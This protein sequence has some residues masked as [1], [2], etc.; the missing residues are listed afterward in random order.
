MNISRSELVQTYAACQENL[1]SDLGTTLMI[2][3]ICFHPFGL[4]SLTKLDAGLGFCWDD[5]QYG[6]METLV[7][8][9]PDIYPE[10]CRLIYEGWSHQQRD[11]A[12][13]AE[14]NALLPY[15][16]DGLV[17]LENIV[18]GIPVEFLGIGIHDEGFWESSR[19]AELAMVF[20][21]DDDDYRDGFRYKAGQLLADGLRPIDERQAHLV[22]WMFSQTGNS[23]ADN[24]WQEGVENFTDSLDWSEMEFLHEM[25]REG[26]KVFDGAMSAIGVLEQDDDLFGTFCANVLI[27]YGAAIQE[28]FHDK[29]A[30]RP[31]FFGTPAAEHSDPG[32]ADPVDSVLPLRDSAAA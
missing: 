31:A 24:S 28:V 3:G 19:A 15:G 13:M 9:F 14:I 12:I 26:E 16:G 11:D 7:E 4:V 2:A 6:T 8:E 17:E 10:Y 20:N 29:R 22:D 21:F 32:G 23:V 27:S 30:V 1:H 25:Y 5:I 18:Y